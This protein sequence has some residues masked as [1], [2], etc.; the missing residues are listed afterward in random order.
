MIAALQRG[1]IRKLGPGAEAAP[2]PF[3]AS[4]SRGFIR[5]EERPSMAATTWERVAALAKAA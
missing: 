1:P 5:T 2:G 3:H 4:N